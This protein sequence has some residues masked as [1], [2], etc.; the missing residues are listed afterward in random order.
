LPQEQWE[1]D[2]RDRFISF[3]GEIRGT[4]YMAGRA[5]VVVDDATGRNFDF[6]LLA[7]NAGEPIALEIFRLT[8]DDA[9]M[10]A[11]HRSHQVLPL[12]ER[13]LRDRGVRSVMIFAPR[14]SFKRSPIARFA[15]EQAEALH[16][17]L[18]VSDN[19]TDV[20]TD[21]GYTIRATP[22]IDDVYVVNF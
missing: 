5:E 18:S 15:V 6:E 20:R 4:P 3:M 1:R 21:Q 2:G 19:A 22:E 13:A 8:E 12:I 17:A 16:S 7:V 9:T 14:L 10:R 11:M